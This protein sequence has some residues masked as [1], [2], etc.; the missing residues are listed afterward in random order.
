M[1]SS[2]SISVTPPEVEPAV[3][4]AYDKTENADNVDELVRRNRIIHPLFLPMKSIRI[5]V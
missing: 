5:S 4:L 2:N 3:V 1:A